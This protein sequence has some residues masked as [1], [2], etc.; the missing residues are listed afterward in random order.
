MT[1]LYNY[2]SGILPRSLENLVQRK[3]R[4]LLY[5]WPQ[6]WILYNHEIYRKQRKHKS[7]KPCR[8]D[9]CADVKPQ[10]EMKF[11]FRDFRN[12]VQFGCQII[13]H[14]TI[15]DFENFAIHL[16]R[17][18]SSAYTIVGFI[19]HKLF[20]FSEGFQFSVKFINWGYLW[21]IVNTL[22]WLRS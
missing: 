4:A 18:I 20:N 13:F 10:A 16:Y 14:S 19:V 22:V 2:E 9:F 17:P 21:S 11:E 3:W 5:R 8:R 1:C 15:L 12:D 6:H 7:K